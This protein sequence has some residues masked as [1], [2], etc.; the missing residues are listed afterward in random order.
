[1][2]LPDL[3]FAVKFDEKIRAS[4]GINEREFWNYDLAQL[5]EFRNVCG[6]LASFRINYGTSSGSIVDNLP[7]ILIFFIFSS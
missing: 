6:Y 3:Q 1:M 5:C 2:Y 7:G 4:H